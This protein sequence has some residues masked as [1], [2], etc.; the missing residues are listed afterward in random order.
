MSTA[1]VLLLR[2]TLRHRPRAGNFFLI[3]PP[4][5]YIGAPIPLYQLPFSCKALHPITQ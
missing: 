3:L 1:Y 2:E 5:A 4:H